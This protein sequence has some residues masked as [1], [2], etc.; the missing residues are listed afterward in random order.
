MTDDNNLLMTSAEVCS[1][2]RLGK[3]KLW[4]MVGEGALPTVKIGRAT[5]FPRDAVLAYV[6]N[7]LEDQHQPVEVAR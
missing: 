6:A 7:L 2:L 3:S 4:Q 1:A 5:R